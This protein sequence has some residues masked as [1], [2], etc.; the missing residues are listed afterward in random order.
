MLRNV[1]RLLN[2]YLL[3]SAEEHSY[4]FIHHEDT[5][6]TKEKQKQLTFF[7]FPSSSLGIAKPK[8]LHRKTGSWSFQI[9]IF[10]LELGNE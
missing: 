6:D 7:W 8:L 1:K 5:K 4:D 3:P 2:D 9:C 10:K